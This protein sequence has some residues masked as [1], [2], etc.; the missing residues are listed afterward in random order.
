M[1]I[2]SIGNSNSNI[3]FTAES[4]YA[5][6]SLPVIIAIKKKKQKQEQAQARE[7]EHQRKLASPKKIDLKA[8]ALYSKYK[9][10]HFKNLLNYY[11]FS[12]FLETL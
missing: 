8:W 11:S 2:Q 1:R 3:G 4:V 12:V 9:L 7:Q 10:S 6:S 5:I